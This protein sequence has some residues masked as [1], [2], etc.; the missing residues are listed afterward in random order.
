VCGNGGSK[1][2]HAEL[3]VADVSEEKAIQYL[4]RFLMFYIMTADRLTRTA[5]W[6]EKMDG[7]MEYL[8]KVVVGDYLGIGKDLEAQM[9]HLIDTYQCEWTTVVRDL[10]R[11]KLFGEFVNTIEPDGPLIEMQEE[12]GQRI[13]VKWPKEVPPMPTVEEQP[14]SNSIDD[15]NMSWVDVGSV[16]LF[17][18]DEGRVVRV[19]KV[20]IAVFHTSGQWFATQNM[21]P[22]KRALVL[23]S[24]IL[25]TTDQQRRYVSCPMH[26]KNFDIKTG[27]CLVP[28]EKDQ[29]KLSTFDVKIEDN[30]VHLFLPPVTVLNEVL[31]T[32]QTIV[33]KGL[34]ET[35]PSVVTFDEAPG[36]GVV[37]QCG[38]KSLE[39]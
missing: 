1:P 25:G 24:G 15:L 10:E 37:S 3:L 16:D 7:G 2:K 39:W 34:K 27:E 38:D 18:D 21:C 17:P 6:L 36:C 30:K 20:Q 12:R 33:T 4:D 5:R 31:G 23:A 28:G 19:G 9:Q 14:A 11:R 32:A 13:P 35:K 8:R 26:K 22:H 29:Y